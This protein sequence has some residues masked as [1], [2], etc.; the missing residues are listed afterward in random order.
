MRAGSNV[1]VDYKS[2][3]SKASFGHPIGPMLAYMAACP[4]SGCESVDL[5]AP[6]WFKV[7]EAGLLNGTYATGYWAMKD[8]YQ[9][10]NL[11]ISTPK[12]LKAGK[13]LL[14]HE[15]INLETGA[16]QFFPNCVQ[17]DVSGDGGKIPEAKE[18]V[19]IAE[20]Y[21]GNFGK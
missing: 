21:D 20:A 9:G 15:M 14:R 6:I 8:V 16:V 1:T 5:L 18:L 2:A 17:L 19:A 12:G 10:A 13:Y 7:W 11:E 3:G 4:S